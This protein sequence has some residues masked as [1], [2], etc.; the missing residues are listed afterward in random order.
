[1]TTF[2]ILQNNQILFQCAILQ[3]LSKSL[4]FTS[5]NAFVDNR[6][7]SPGTLISVSQDGI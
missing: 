1:M 5:E 7:H 2:V 3:M 6:L 4:H